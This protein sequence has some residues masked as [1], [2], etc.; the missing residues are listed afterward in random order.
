[1]TP[2]TPLDQAWHLHLTYT[3]SYWERSCGEILGK[4]V[5]HHPTK[6]GPAE[7]RKY[8]GQYLQTLRSYQKIFGTPPNPNI[9]PNLTDWHE[10]S[11]RSPRVNKRRN[12]AALRLMKGNSTPIK[13]TALV[14]GLTTVA[15]ILSPIFLANAQNSTESDSNGLWLIIFVFAAIFGWNFF[16]GTKMSRLWSKTG[17]RNDWG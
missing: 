4:A 10:G 15:L 12:W 9:W 11:A 8:R 17:T 7:A 6:G 14:G 3:S 2:S 1:M 13:R 5:H 16:I